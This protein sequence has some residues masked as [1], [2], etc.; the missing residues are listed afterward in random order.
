MI[1]PRHSFALGQMPPDA[2]GRRP[3]ALI[4]M[5]TKTHSEVVYLPYDE[6]ADILIAALKLAHAARHY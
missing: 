6:A 4:I 1:E 2:D 5:D 3:Q